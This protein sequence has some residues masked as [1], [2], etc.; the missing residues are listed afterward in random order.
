MWYILADYTVERTMSRVSTVCSM[1]L[2]LYRSTVAAP[3]LVLPFF[4]F[5][6]RQPDSAQLINKAYWTSCDA[7]D[8][9]SVRFAPGTSSSQKF[10]KVMAYPI[11]GTSRLLMPFGVTIFVTPV[12]IKRNFPQSYSRQTGFGKMFPKKDI[13]L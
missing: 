6:P 1:S 11:P 12:L 7:A 9:I 13:H 8:G 4:F 3:S 5:P 10:P 2:F